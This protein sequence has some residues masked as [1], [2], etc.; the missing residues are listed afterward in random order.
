[1]K[2]GIAL[3]R[4]DEIDSHRDIEESQCVYQERGPL[5]CEHLLG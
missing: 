5:T 1:M 4:G 2:S 3:A